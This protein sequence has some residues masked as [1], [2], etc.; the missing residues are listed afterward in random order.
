MTY[1]MVVA[2]DSLDMHTLDCQAVHHARGAGY[3]VQ[4]IETDLNAVLVGSLAAVKAGVGDY[5]V[6]SCLPRPS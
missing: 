3:D 6:H 2:G 5:K 1:A 4:T